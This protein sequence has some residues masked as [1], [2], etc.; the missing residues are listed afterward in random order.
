MFT[1]KRLRFLF[2]FII[3]FIS[4][5]YFFSNTTF[6]STNVTDDI[7]SNTTWSLSGSP[8]IVQN[9][10]NLAQDVN[11]TIDAGVVVKF[12]PYTELDM[13][14]GGTFQ[15]NGT[16]T[17]KIYFTSLL[18]DEVDGDTNGDGSATTPDMSDT[19]NTL[20]YGLNFTN[21]FS[22]AT[23]HIQLHNV[24]VRYADTGL[25]LCEIQETLVQDSTLEKNHTGIYD[26]GQSQVTISNT[27]VIH[28]TI[29]IHLNQQ[30]DL[31]NSVYTVNGSSISNN[32]GYGVLSETHAAPLANNW[33]KPLHWIANLFSPQ[34]AYADVYTYTVDFRNTWWG[35]ASGPLNFASNTN[36]L[37]DE[38]SGDIL[39]SPWLIIDPFAPV[40]SSNVLFIPGFEGSRLYKTRV[41][42]T[43]DQL[44]EPNIGSDVIALSMTSS[45]TSQNS[46]IYTKD[47][48]RSTN[49]VLGLVHKNI[50]KSFM[51]SLD[52]M[53]TDSTIHAWAGTPYDWRYSPE[54]VVDH[55][56]LASNGRIS[57]TGTVPSGQSP[58]IISQLQALADTSD[59]GK[60]T[61]VTHSNGGL[62]VKALIRKLEMMHNTGTSDL[63]TKIDKV[64]MVSAP[65]IGTPDALGAM[66]HGNGTEIGPY[67]IILNETTAR[68]FGKN[69]PDAYNLLPSQKYFDV[70][71]TAMNPV[72]KFDSALDGVNNFHQMYG[73]SITSYTAMKNFLLGILD[74]RTQPVAT[75]L[76]SPSILNSALLN[77]AKNEH[78]DLDNY[79][80][81]SSI[82]LYKIAGWGEATSKNVFYTIKD[83][84]VISNFICHP[85]LDEK[86]ETTIDGDGTVVSPSAVY[87]DGTK[88]YFN[89]FAFNNHVTNYQHPDIF[90]ASPLVTAVKNLITGD[91][92]LST[93]VTTAKPTDSDNLTLSIHS[94]VTI[95][96]Y[97]SAGRHTGLS[98][99]QPYTDM[100][101]IDEEIPNS[102]YMPFGEGTY[103]NVPSGE[104]YTV[105]ISG[106]DFG[107]FTFEKEHHVNDQSVD[108]I[109]FNDIPVTPMTEATLTVAPSGTASQISV[110]VDGD[111]TTDATISA[112]ADFDPILYLEMI[113]K[114]ILKMN[115]S[116]NVKNQLI[117]KINH[118]KTEIQ[119]GHI[120]NAKHK[121]KALMK[122]VKLHH[123]HR[124]HHVDQSDKQALLDMF[125]QLLDN[126][127]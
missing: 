87:G 13:S 68:T 65:E 60:V 59:T 72:I 69:V 74:N 80:I 103:V 42:G 4:V 116:N 3:S 55:G 10:I 106:T 71:D 123:G 126:L 20:W 95:D 113:K 76:I 25:S 14:D 100:T 52:A 46:A 30:D 101:S 127:S 88:Y 61:I 50:Y 119:N 35:D 93:Y 89:V 70:V 105:N 83:D 43:E 41:T 96:V 34:K 8:Y 122:N 2:I 82:Q 66:L 51:D 84:C 110:D 54:Y 114:T 48:I 6:A 12:A 33:E 29:G 77:S 58:F 7:T 19:S 107:T 63:I 99:T 73:D 124:E 21:C 23:T 38:I 31:P 37:G 17:D 78:T 28:N 112:G 115:L 22:Q 117:N 47:I 26:R 32:T 109:S 125:N 97:D 11:L 98:A 39:F 102:S 1:I 108:D 94:P 27:K 24:V 40:G 56:V 92:P 91:S 75:D 57:Y 16:V 118:L 45:G 62:V 121:L 64:I 104:S 79:H 81:P 111:G 85:I 90:E 53:V 36:G 5:F 9:N 120:Q 18:D 44:W 49:L 67:G 15:A 86:L